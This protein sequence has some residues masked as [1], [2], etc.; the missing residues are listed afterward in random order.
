MRINTKQIIIRL[1]IIALL[2]WGGYIA[3]SVFFDAFLNKVSPPIRIFP[4]FYFAIGYLFIGI[5][6]YLLIVTLRVLI[7]K[8]Q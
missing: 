1:I 2:F 6:M 3:L 4:Q 7:K 8:K 5:G